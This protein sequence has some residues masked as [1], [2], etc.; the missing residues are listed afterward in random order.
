MYSTRH[1]TL[2]AL[3]LL[4]SAAACNESA[5]L[6][7]VTPAAPLLAAATFGAAGAK[8]EHSAAAP[9]T[10]NPESMQAGS[11]AAPPSGADTALDCSMGAGTS[12]LKVAF[13]CTSV[14]S[15]TCKDLSNI[16]LEFADGTRQRFDI[17]ASLDEQTYFCSRAN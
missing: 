13:R 8:A 6:Q 2:F 10:N 12:P 14:T 16:V 5:P 3:P 1:K 11:N 15:Y 17:F 9:K 7:P 4:L